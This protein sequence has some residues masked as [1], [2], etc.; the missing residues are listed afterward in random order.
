MKS[1]ISYS[2]FRNR[3]KFNPLSLFFIDNN[4]SYEEF[5]EYFNTRDIE[6]PN[7]EYYNRVKDKFKETSDNK[8]KDNISVEEEKKEENVS[9]IEKPLEKQKKTRKKSKKRIEKKDV[10]DESN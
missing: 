4:I 7:V 10:K 3:T 8:T 5:K 1:Y 9:I 6:S 2:L